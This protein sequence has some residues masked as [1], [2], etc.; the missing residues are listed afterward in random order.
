M[1]PLKTG[2]GQRWRYST[3]EREQTG[4]IKHTKETRSKKKKK[5]KLGNKVQFYICK[6]ISII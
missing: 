1:K 5:K 6:L 3:G 4:E 2:F